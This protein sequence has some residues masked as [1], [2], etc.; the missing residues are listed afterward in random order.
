MN[1]ISVMYRFKTLLYNAAGSEIK[2]ISFLS[3]FRLIK[4]ITFYIFF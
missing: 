3:V 1:K 2:R 4:Y